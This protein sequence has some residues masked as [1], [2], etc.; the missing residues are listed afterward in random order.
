MPHSQ[1]DAEYLHLQLSITGM[2]LLTTSHVYRR[3]VNRDTLAR[4]ETGATET[5]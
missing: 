1:P 5:S 3:G 2:S 4:D